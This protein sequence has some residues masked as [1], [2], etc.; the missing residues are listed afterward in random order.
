MRCLL[1]F[2]FSAKIKTEVIN[3]NYFISHSNKIFDKDY[4]D[5]FL[6][7]TK[8]FSDSLINGIYW[9]IFKQFNILKRSRSFLSTG[10]GKALPGFLQLSRLFIDSFWQVLTFKWRKDKNHHNVFFS[11]K[12]LLEYEIKNA[13]TANIH[14]LFYGIW[15]KN[16]F[17]RLTH[18]VNVIYQDE[19]YEDGR[20]ISRAL[21]SYDHVTTIGLQHGLFD[22]HHTVYGISELEF[23]KETGDPLPSPKLFV[24]W[25]E[26]F[27]NYFLSN[28]HFDQKRIKVLGNLRYL[29][30]E[31]PSIKRK[32]KKVLW[33]TST[34]ELAKNEIL[35]LGNA[36]LDNDE[37][38]VTLREH[39]I[40]KY[41]DELENTLRIFERFPKLKVSTRSLILD[42][43]R[44]HDL[45]IVNCFTT[46]FLDASLNGKY[47][48]RLFP[49]QSYASYLKEYKSQLVFNIF[50]ESD[51]YFVLDKIN[52]SKINIDIQNEAKEIVN[53]HIPKWKQLLVNGFMNVA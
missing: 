24:V 28:N 18:K 16:Y 4:E 32:I 38:E 26:F 44:Y 36:I 39:P 2:R 7:D 8:H 14:Y 33:C 21:E 46:V 42:E 3:Q 25:G 20:I 11:D 48:L 9:P 53:I 51:V 13:I 41:T 47:C 34:P 45:I 5:L 37:Y 10:Y 30:M 29:N 22:L 23:N 1:L 17:S 52:T 35:L 49:Y 27:K 50:S 19:F 6:S 12:L 15:L 31:V 43:I 40:Y